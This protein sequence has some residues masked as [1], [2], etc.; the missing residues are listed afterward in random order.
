MTYDPDNIFAK[1]LRNEIPCNKAFESDHTL[2]FH[3]IA[4]LAPT[5]IL[6]IPKGAYT[7]LVDFSLNAPVEAQT[8]FLKAVAIIAQENN[9]TQKGFRSITNTGDHGGQEVPHFHL[10]MLGGEKIG[11]LRPS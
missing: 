8:D 11:K 3:D 2:A 9:L 10:H 4:P 7:D 5:H 6:V 1:I